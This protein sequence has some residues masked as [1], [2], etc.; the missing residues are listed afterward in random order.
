MVIHPIT[1]VPEALSE[2][3]ASSVS[4]WNI[5]ESS[6]IL[7]SATVGSYR[8]DLALFTE[9]L[10][11][12]A[13]AEDEVDQQVARGFT[14]GLSRRGLAPASV[15]RIVSAVR[16][17]Y[18]YRMQQGVTAVNPFSAVRSLPKNRHLPEFLFE[19]EVNALIDFEPGD[20]WELRD[21]LFFELLYSTGCRIAELVSINIGSIDQKKHSILVLG[22]GGK[23]RYVFLGEPALDV[24]REY[25]AKRPEHIDEK[26]SDAARALLL[27]RHGRRITVRGVSFILKK[28]L[29]QSSVMKCVSPHT[30]RHTFATQLLDHGADIRIV[31]ELLGHANLSTTQIYT[32][33]GINRLKDIYRSA[34]PHGRGKRPVP[35]GGTDMKSRTESPVINETVSKNEK[36]GNV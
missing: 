27:N 12:E 22:K 2:G 36:E 24:L 25:L 20:F 26:D 19:N 8:K 30:F 16:G 15:N 17:Y 9:F 31:Q 1:G 13:I 29:L 35:S 11:R 7:S 23:E 32:H 28:Y 4:T 3:K 18:R 34:H 21:K 33:L 5:W 10:S 6:S 14:A